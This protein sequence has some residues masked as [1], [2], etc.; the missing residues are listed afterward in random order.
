MFGGGKWG[1]GSDH[2]TKLTFKKVHRYYDLYIDL[3]MYYPILS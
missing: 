2:F 3:S 1:G